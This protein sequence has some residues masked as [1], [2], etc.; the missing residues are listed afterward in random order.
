[1]PAST[2]CC[3]CSPIGRRRFSNATKIVGI[4]LI[5]FGLAALGYGGITDTTTET[6]VDIGA[7]K[8]TA[9]RERTFP[10]QPV[11]VVIA[12]VGGVAL[13]VGSMHKRT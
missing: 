6:V 8:A 2:G 1:M 3:V 11:A 10:L 4:V 12:V 13:L 5:V 7:F 9:D